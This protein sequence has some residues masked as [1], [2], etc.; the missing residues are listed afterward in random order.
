MEIIKMKGRKINT[1][2]FLFNSH[3]NVQFTSYFPKRGKIVLMLSTT[4]EGRTVSAETKKPEF[5]QFYNST[6]GG[7]DTFDQMCHSF[8]CSRKTRHWPLRIFYIMTCRRN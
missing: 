3:D 4:R 2:V 5:V 6:K 8:T 1:C 7:V